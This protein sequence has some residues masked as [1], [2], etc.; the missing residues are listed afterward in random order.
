MVLLWKAILH[1]YIQCSERFEDAVGV[2]GKLLAI[3]MHNNE[4]PS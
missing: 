2:L 4:T 1:T 3:D